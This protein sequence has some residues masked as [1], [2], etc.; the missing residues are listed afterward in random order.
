M[1][2]PNDLAGFRAAL[3]EGDRRLVR[4]RRTR[5]AGVASAF[6]AAALLVGLVLPGSSLDT[7]A[8][9]AE[10]RQALTRPGILHSQ[11]EIVL[12]DGRVHQTIERWSMGT[13]SRTISVDRE[14]RRVE[15]ATDGTTIQV[16]LEP[17]G[18]VDTLP[19][20]TPAPDPL[21]AYREVLDRATSVEEVRIDGVD[22]YRFAV[23]GEIPQVA[24]VRR[25]DRLPLRVELE[26][27]VTQRIR[28]EWLRADP[29]LLALT[30]R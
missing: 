4:R 23:S 6:V 30:A 16:R 21:L 8:L 20:A 26:G 13:R 3:L 1:S 22:A 29:A 11:V 10:A 7:A 28:T 25:S 27:G 9:A 2:N 14:G 18:P 24:Y 17:G 5:A 19:N 12:P 15:Q